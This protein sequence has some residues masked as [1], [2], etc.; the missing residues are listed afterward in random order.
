LRTVT[1]GFLP[2]AAA[3]AILLP[4]A[5]F[6]ASPPEILRIPKTPPAPVLDAVVLSP[7]TEIML[8][9][10]QTPVPLD[11]ARTTGPEDYGDMR[12]QANSVFGKIKA[13]L[14][15]QGF[16]MKDVVKLTVF[17]V[18]DPKL[19]GRADFDAMNEV[20][21]TFFGTKDNPNLPARSALQVAALGKPG[22]RIE[23]E[24]IVARAHSKQVVPGS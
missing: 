1:R 15:G 5:G 19:G 20:Y 23:V 6:T 17:V 12:R 18:G 22:Y 10:G 16:S 4:A 13:V 11:P 14:E 7:G 3:G 8:I 9:S 24:A 2:L 21:G